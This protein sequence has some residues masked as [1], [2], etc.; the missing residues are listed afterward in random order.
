MSRQSRFWQF[1]S[2]AVAA[3]LVQSFAGCEPALAPEATVPGPEKSGLAS[4]VT[5]YI[6]MGQLSGGITAVRIPDQAEAVVRPPSLDD[7]G[8]TPTIHALTGPDQDGRIAYIEDHFF[9]ADERARRQPAED[10]QARWDARY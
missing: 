4:G 1:I 5:G 10:N 3:M 2:A 6:V 7:A 8:D 9:V